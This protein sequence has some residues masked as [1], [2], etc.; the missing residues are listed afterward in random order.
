MNGNNFEQI[1]NDALTGLGKSATD[2]GDANRTYAAERIA[3]LATLVGQAGYAE[4][5]KAE[6]ESIAMRVAI[7]AVDLADAG[8]ARVVGV[9][10]GILLTGAKGLLA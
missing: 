6:A 2:L 3:Y 5:A 10:Q 1:L 8:D 4:A 7:G 9:I